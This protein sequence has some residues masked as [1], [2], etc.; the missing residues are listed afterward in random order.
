MGK[1]SFSD[2]LVRIAKILFAYYYVCPMIFILL[3]GAIFDFLLNMI[4]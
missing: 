4:E 1:L 2:M 3:W